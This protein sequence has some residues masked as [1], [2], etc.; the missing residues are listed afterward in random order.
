MSVL[1]RKHFGGLLVRSWNP[2]GLLLV[3]WDLVGSPGG[4]LIAK[5]VVV[6]LVVVIM[7]VMD[8]L[9]SSTVWGIYTA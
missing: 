4:L 9:C 6:L 2:G 7:V 3:S 1:A 5:V 8:V